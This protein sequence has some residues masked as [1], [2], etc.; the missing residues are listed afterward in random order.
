MTVDKEGPNKAAEQFRGNAYLGS[1]SWWR[2][3]LGIL[4]ILVIWQGIGSVPWFVACE[5][6]TQTDGPNFSCDGLTISG[7]SWTPNFILGLYPFLIGIIGLWL[8]VKLLHRKS[9][10]Q[11]VTGRTTFDYNRVVFAMFIGL[12]LS[13]TW[14]VITVVI[15]QSEVSVQN[16]NF[17]DYLTFFLFAIV[18]IPYQAGFEEIFF[19]GY[20]LQGFML[21]RSGKVFLLTTSALIFTLPHLANPEPWTYGVVPY[22]LSLLL[23]GTF[24]TLITLLDGGIE[25]AVGY[26]AMNNL[27]II[28]VANTEVSALQG[29]SLFIFPIEKYELFPGLLVEFATYSLATLIFSYWYRWFHQSH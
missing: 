2:W 15:F 26:H 22:V 10:T 7:D 21:F 5:Y 23:F 18:L 29:P 11:V 24:L 28:L 3:L 1:N 20:L 13:T 25:L 12:C 8:A 19:R 9:L 4:G 17:W 14:F 16:L 27:F 6:L